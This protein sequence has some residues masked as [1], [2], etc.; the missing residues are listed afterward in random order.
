MRF[1]FFLSND[2][3]TIFALIGFVFCCGLCALT[4][5]WELKSRFL[6]IAQTKVKRPKIDANK[7]KK[8]LEKKNEIRFQR[9][10][11]GIIM[12]CGHYVLSP[13]RRFLTSSSQQS[14]NFSQCSVN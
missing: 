9:Y 13:H 3:Q 6:F 14:N 2:P 1:S 10:I 8:S 12:T 4:T 7:G 5:N 11:E